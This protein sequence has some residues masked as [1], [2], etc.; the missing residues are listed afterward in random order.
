MNQNSNKN[1]N[2]GRFR[3]L[4]FYVIML[5]MMLA[6][7]YSMLRD[8]TPDVK[9]SYSDVLNLF[10]EEKVESFALSMDGELVMELK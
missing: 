8:A 1:P 2:S 3:Q 10:R 4:G 7:V 9:L 5:V 6:S